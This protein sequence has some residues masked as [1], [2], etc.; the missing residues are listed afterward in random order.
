MITQT[1]LKCYRVPE[2]I[3]KKEK[4]GKNQS[5]TEVEL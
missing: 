2:E 3:R 4:S 1:Y 5:A